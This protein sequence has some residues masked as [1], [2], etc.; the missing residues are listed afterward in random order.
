MSAQIYFFTKY[1]SKGASS[2]YR[3]LQYLKHI[4]E[5]F[6]YKVLPLFDN[7]Y[8]EQL[9]RT[10]KKPIIKA[11]L[12]YCLRLIHLFKLLWNKESIFVIENELW[13][14]IPFS[15]EKL[16][17]RGKKRIVLIYDDAIFHHYDLSSNV[18]LQKNK[19]KIG[20]LMCT[21]DLTIVGNKYLAQYAGNWTKNIT[22]IPTVADK[23]KY[24]KK[25]YAQYSQETNIITNTNTNQK[26]NLLWIGSPATSHY[27]LELE[28]LFSDTWF[29]NNVKLTLVGA[30]IENKNSEL[31]S[32][33]KNPFQAEIEYVNWNE[34]NEVSIIQQCD[35]GIM[36]LP[37]DSWSKGKCG[38]KLIQYMLAG[39]PC[40]AS[41]V[42]ANVDIVVD[43]KTGFLA[44]TKEEWLHCLQEFH[45]NR[46]LIESN[47]RAG[48]ERALA[49]YT[50]D[51][52]KDNW[53][54]AILG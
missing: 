38:F 39:L 20:E 36:P 10:G 22:I 41:P 48:R 29:I 54:N 35:I 3:T 31:K 50:I 32:M 42:G 18:Y 17:L 46:D 8:I 47:G 27:L 52:T 4:P 13:P 23:Q 24:E 53:L 15:I 21:A 14:Y 12:S 28:D 43:G 33:S 40:I 11:F 7:S 5:S 44:N 19:N 2:R 37:N 30:R 16:F 25:N 51:A 45:N 9:Y 34:A 6:H 1:A 26:L 49:L